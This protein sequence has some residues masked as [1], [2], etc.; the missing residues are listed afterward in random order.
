MRKR[1]GSSN[2]KVLKKAYDIY[3]S[4]T[5][6][7]ID[8]FWIV[9]IKGNFLDANDKYCQLIGYS[10]NELL[11]MNISDIDAIETPRETLKHIKKI[12]DKSEDRFLT[13]HRGKN[14]KIIDLE[15][16]A[17]YIKDMGGLIF[18]FLRDISSRRKVDLARIKIRSESRARMQGQLS[19]SYSYMGVINRKISLLL[20][21]AKYR[22]PRGGRQKIIDHVLSL[23]V[24]LSHASTGF[25]YSSSGRG[26][27]YLLSSHGVG[28]N[29]VQTI[30]EI[31]IKSVGL[32]RHLIKEK[33]RIAGNIQQYKAEL[34]K[35]NRKVDYFITLP[36]S[37]DNKLKGFIFLGFDNDK[38]LRKEDEEFLDIFA[39][40]ASS[41]LAKA[42][43]LDRK[44]K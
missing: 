20:E 31:S 19:D 38:A 28:K 30:E 32:L 3:H 14:S 36:L 22:R 42:G 43:V 2:H 34:L 9:D 27:F 23:A 11:G 25:L 17:N 37:R 18:V 33:T 24:S 44:G 15:I 12:I 1:G 29:K 16:S 35:L 6:T 8:G 21:L 4:I 40:H 39:I 26:K 10:R 7:A 13:R 5:Q 41:A